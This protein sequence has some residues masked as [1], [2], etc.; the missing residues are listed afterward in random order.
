MAAQDWTNP[1]ITALGLQLAGD[2][3]DEVDDRGRHIQDDTLLILLNP[4]W[5]PIAFSLPHQPS[6]GRWLLVAD[7]RDRLPVP[8]R[9]PLRARGRYR[10]EPRTLALFC[11]EEPASHNADILEVGRTPAFEGRPAAGDAAAVPVAADGQPAR[12]PLAED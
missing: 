5:K 6:G 3:I 7:T 9:R 2:A 10:M 1:A 12:P 8:G 4:H 11:L